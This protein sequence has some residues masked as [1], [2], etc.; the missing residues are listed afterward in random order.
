[1]IFIEPYFRS[2]L[3]TWSLLIFIDR[4]LGLIQHV[5]HLLSDSISLTFSP[6][7]LCG[8]GRHDKMQL[9][10]L[11]LCLITR[12]GVVILGDFNCISKKNLSM[13]PQQPVGKSLSRVF[14]KGKPEINC[15]QHGCNKWYLV[16]SHLR[17]R[18]KCSEYT[19]KIM[20]IQPLYIHDYLR[21]SD[22]DQ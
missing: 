2:I 1:M 6:Q 17:M 18:V 16:L 11:Y 19:L 13:S 5:L 10:L 3:E 15:L 8:N 4:H 12:D 9:F 20:T 22:F 21:R 14:L 7:E